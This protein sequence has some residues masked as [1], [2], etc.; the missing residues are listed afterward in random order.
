MTQR[1]EPPASVPQVPPND[2]R[3]SSTMPY[4][5]KPDKIGL[6]DLRDPKEWR[7]TVSEAAEVAWLKEAERLTNDTSRKF[8]DDLCKEINAAVDAAEQWR[9]WGAE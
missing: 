1:S 5:I 3:F 7:R 9:K 8:N 2:G 4:F 6:V